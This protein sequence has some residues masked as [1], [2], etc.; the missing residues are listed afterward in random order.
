MYESKSLDARG[1]AEYSSTENETWAILYERQTKIIQNRACDEYLQ[2]LEILN[3]PK[4]RVP[5]CPEITQRLREAT[6]WAVQPVPKLISLKNFFVLIANRHFPA[7]TF[8]RTREDLDYLREPDIFHEFFGHCP[9]LTN[10]AYAN[11]VESYGKMALKA[12]PEHLSILG[13]LFWFTIEFG[14]VKTPQGL[15]IYGGGILSSF[16]ETQYALESPIPNRLDFN[17]RQVMKTTYRYDELQKIYYILNS[18]EDLFKINEIDLLGLIEKIA[19][20][21]DTSGDFITC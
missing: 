17:I 1:F 13:R 5:Q 16:E 8:I 12:K 14:L 10:P 9:L 7:A 21:T 6:G 11:F 19:S 20:S 15:R 18:I 4:D 3:M 2:G